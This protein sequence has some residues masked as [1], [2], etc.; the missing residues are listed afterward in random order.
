MKRTPLPL[1]EGF[2]E[3]PFEQRFQGLLRQAW[4]LKRWH[5][6]V[7]EPGSGKTMGIRDLSA[8]ASREAGMVGGRRYPVLAV[9][10]PKNDAKEAA[11][12]NFL[13]T[14][15]GLGARGHWSERTYRLFELLLQYG[16]ECLVIDDAHDLSMPHLIFLRIADR[17]APINLSPLCSGV[18][19]VPGGSGTGSN[20]AA[21][22]CLRSTRNDVA[23]ISAQARSCPT[24]L[25][26]CQP[27]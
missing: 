2:I 24:V 19:V 26:D 7:A 15:L 20:D 22:R 16:V 12:G 8:Q 14:A 10:A 9:T 18:G 3:T 13:L 1:F 4:K 25:S 11:L 5:V 27:Y 17:S 21:Q 6:I 23:A